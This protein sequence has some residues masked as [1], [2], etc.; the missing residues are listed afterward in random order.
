MIAHS[1]DLVDIPHTAALLRDPADQFLTCCFTPQD[2]EAVG[3]GKDRAARLSDRLAVKEA[4]MVHP[5]SGSRVRRCSRSRTATGS[6]PQ[7][8]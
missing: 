1:I 2:R 5:D 6:A 3:T 8:N 7:R 4:V